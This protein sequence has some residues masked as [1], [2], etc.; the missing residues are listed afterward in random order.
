M[1]QL[2]LQF[3]ILLSHKP[4]RLSDGS[5]SKESVYH[6]QPL[7]FPGLCITHPRLKLGKEKFKKTLKKEFKKFATF[8]VSIA[9][10][11]KLLWYTFSPELHFSQKQL[12]F[13]TGRV[14]IDALVPVV[15]YTWK[16]YKYLCLPNI[17]YY[18]VLLGDESAK[19]EDYQIIE[20][21]QDFFRLQKEKETQK[22]L[23]PE[24]YFRKSKD[25]MSLINHTIWY[26]YD[27]FA[28]SLREEQNKNFFS[29]LF[30]EQEFV[31][32][33][34]I[35]KVGRKLE[36]SSTS[37]YSN[38]SIRNKKEEILALV[39][40]PQPTSIALIGKIGS[41]KTKL[42]QEALAEIYREEQNRISYIQST[43]K[44]RPS[45]QFLQTDTWYVNPLQVISGMSIVGQWE[46]RFESILQ[47]LS[48]R[49]H[50]LYK[51]FNKNERKS[52]DEFL[53]SPPYLTYPDRLYI[54]NAVA[55]S[56]TGQTAQSNLSLADVLK[57]YIEKQKFSVILEATPEEWARFREFDY[58]FTE[59]FTP[60]L[61]EEPDRKTIVSII[62]QKRNEIERKKNK[63]I[64]NSALAYLVQSTSKFLPRN[65]SLLAGVL[66]L[67]EN[68]FSNLKKVELAN[69]KQS[70]Q[71]RY[72]FGRWLND[73]NLLLSK[74]EIL[75][76]LD[77]RIIGQNT[78]KEIFA[79]T[80]LTLKANLEEADKPIASLLLIGP[81]GVG[82]T[83]SA[84]ALAEY[85]FGSAE[86]LMRFNMN[87]YVD[88]AATSRLLGSPQNPDGQL[89]NLIRQ[90]KSGVLLLDEIEKAHPLVHD[91]LLQVIGEGRLTD[92]Q[93]RVADF[94]NVVILLTSNLGASNATA[95]IGF[96]ADT[97][98]SYIYQKA[99]EEFF[100]P[101]FLNRLD[102]IIP[103]ENLQKE[104]VRDLVEKQ[105]SEILT[106]E[107]FLRRTIL[108]SLKPSVV[109]S[110]VEANFAYE[111][112]VRALKRN[113]ERELVFLSA[114]VLVDLNTDLPIVLEL[115]Y[116]NQSIKPKI[117]AIPFTHKTANIGIDLEPWRK[118]F[119]KELQICLENARYF[120]ENLLQSI[121]TLADEDK[122][123][124]WKFLDKI[125]ENIFVLEELVYDDE[126]SY[127][128]VP[129]V[130][131]GKK[132]HTTLI[133][134]SHMDSPTFTNIDIVSESLEEVYSKSPIYA[135]ETGMRLQ[136][137]LLVDAYNRYFYDKFVQR[138]SETLYLYCFPFYENKDQQQELEILIEQYLDF[139][140]EIQV[141]VEEKRYASY[142]KLCISG[143]GVQQLFASEEGFHFFKQDHQ[144]VNPIYIK[145][146]KTPLAKGDREDVDLYTK[147]STQRIYNLG[148]QKQILL[149][150]DLRTGLFFRNGLKGKDF[151]LLLHTNILE[152]SNEST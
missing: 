69:A 20:I 67:L 1:S 94:S 42:L 49:K 23:P 34:E 142:T 29:S 107:G 62:M 103:Y 121:E 16:Q 104:N 55:L 113:I 21:I 109:D 66:D 65:Q 50:R 52:V 120:E 138:G 33:E 126:K 35:E 97:D 18:T 53:A 70:V 137:F 106:R 72:H 6:L 32:Q 31:G 134:F 74:R 91:L 133:R 27:V 111:L 132:R 22:T 124:P 73:P 17:E 131:R 60:V 100:R 129:V 79:N 139:C 143:F 63:Q 81:T 96:A 101:E 112:G 136:E 56:T 40:T 144:A 86:K 19:C 82:K 117:T 90:R 114:A 25:S 71:K 39:N 147:F 135:D 151:F 24:E 7:L 140:E 148:A 130:F 38:T 105:I 4:M 64:S 128:E 127:L 47:F 41:G 118:N 87:E 2:T 149:V 14:S 95:S 89:S 83:E 93:G 116:Q 45:I 88:Y 37:F 36:K 92:F 48:E 57:P 12:F 68:L 84:K 146:S 13:K 30:G 80:I 99:I 76:F 5:L 119:R 9:D 28:A 125:R 15:I 77:K 26:S 78:A 150:R 3:P 145:L 115:K 108:L 122:P 102:A 58:H 44:A 10:S 11:S 54:R 85:F 61:L 8:G 51:T 141:I 43:S 123:V 75:D 152:A 98:K 110:L 46:D 59:L